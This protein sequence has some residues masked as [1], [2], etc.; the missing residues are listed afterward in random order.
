M[1]PPPVSQGVGENPVEAASDA[2]PSPPRRELL[3]EE[4]LEEEPTPL[5]VTGGGG[6][7]VVGFG[8][9]GAEEGE[10]ESAEPLEVA[11]AAASASRQGLEATAFLADEE[12][13]SAPEPDPIRV[14]QSLPA[15]GDGQDRRPRTRSALRSRGNWAEDGA[16]ALDGVSLPAPSSRA[17]KVAAVLLIAAGLGAGAA[18]L[19]LNLTGKKG[20]APPGLAPPRLQKG[21]V[22]KA[23]AKTAPP[24]KGEMVAA[25]EKKAPTAP[26]EK[27]TVAGKA[28]PPALPGKASP[29]KAQ[30]DLPV[31]S[32]KPA[33]A[34]AAA[35]AT[36][37]ALPSPRLAAAPA[38]A[39][40]GAASKPTIAM[41]GATPTG[42][43]GAALRVP[44]ASQPAGA[45]VWV[46]GQ[47]RGE[48]P[49]TVQLRP[50]TA[51]VVL[52]HPGYLTSQSTLEVRE[53]AKVDE[54]LKAV[55]PPMTGEARFRAEC[56]T[57]GKFPI[58]VDGKET[59]ILCPF[60][61]MRVEPGTHTIGLL[62]PATGQVHQKE[63]I[64]FAGVRSVVFKD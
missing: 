10:A 51:R 45:R 35:D 57:T 46:D 20:T 38:K 31:A 32:A 44:F 56:Q 53:G 13:Q 4:L 8:A 59:G 49:C 60:S 24:E 14:A 23:P 61:K 27:A 3:E 54:T 6:G 5:L 28:G 36:A 11:T 19:M 18:A 37:K 30:P 50:G 7:E 12:A 63:V 26:V 2:L 21:A 33:P 17:K 41:A 25:P 47:E 62:I 9:E 48:T 1:G 15:P 55:E 40:E 42:P 22:T 16:D 29:G 43:L 34:A 58:V 39:Q 64:L 52:V